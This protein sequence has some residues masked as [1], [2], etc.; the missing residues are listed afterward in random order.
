MV[1]GSYDLWLADDPRIY[2]FTRTL[3]DVRWL[4]LLNFS[5]EPAPY[6]F[7]ATLA[8]APDELVLANYAD[9]TAAAESARQGTLRPWEARVYRVTWGQ[10]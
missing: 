7:D 1:Y 10:A 2:A 3:G 9:R 8:G 5:S 6:A 4:V